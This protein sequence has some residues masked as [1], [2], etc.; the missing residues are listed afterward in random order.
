MAKLIQVFH[1][2]LDATAL[3]PE[4]AAST[5]EERGWVRVETIEPEIT[6]LKKGSPRKR[7]NV[8]QSKESDLE[9]E[10]ITSDDHQEE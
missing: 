7:G 10:E 9:S 8:S 5:Y 3:V 1:D 2:E 4:A 6:L